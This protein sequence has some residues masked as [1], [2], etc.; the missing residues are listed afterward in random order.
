MSMQ[1]KQNTVPKNECPFT[2]NGAIL[3]RFTPSN[4]M[5]ERIRWARTSV[6][7]ASSPVDVLFFE[8]R[9][10]EVGIKY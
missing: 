7:E 5:A 9:V 3:Y 8:D 10:L 6:A 2:I 1:E 4:F